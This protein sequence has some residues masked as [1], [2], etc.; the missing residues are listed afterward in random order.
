M[1]IFPYDFFGRRAFLSN[2]L[3]L[4]YHRKLF[5]SS[6]FLNHKFNDY[7]SILY[8]LRN[9]N[10]WRKENDFTKSNAY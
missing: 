1:S 3:N 6:T 7:L 2:S 8:Y 5:F 9:I 4:L 10:E